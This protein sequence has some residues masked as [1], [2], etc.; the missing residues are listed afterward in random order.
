[1]KKATATVLMIVAGTLSA[2]CENRAPHPDAKWRI[3]FDK[4]AEWSLKG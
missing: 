4:P 1:M 3:R 2:M